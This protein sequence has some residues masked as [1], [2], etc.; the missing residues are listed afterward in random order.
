MAPYHTD[1]V[2]TFAN[3]S[4]LHGSQSGQLRV[5]HRLY[6]REASVL[7]TT[8]LGRLVRTAVRYLDHF[9]RPPDGMVRLSANLV[10]NERGAVLVAT[11]GLDVMPAERRLARL[12]WRRS[13]GVMPL[14]DSESLEVV[15]EPARFS[16]EDGV[17]KE[18]GTAWPPEPGESGVEPGRYPLQAVVLLGAHAD[19]LVA[20]ST[21]RRRAGYAALLDTAYE[22]ARVP[23]IEIVG[24]LD[25]QVPTV[26]VAGFESPEVLDVLR[27]LAN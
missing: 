1:V 6:R 8:S 27:R 16:I 26:R 23:D 9:V 13:D 22:S 7:R 10:V 5:L 24:R 14:L 21:A 4:L 19:H 20:E 25:G 15:V 2:T 17:A 11:G 18:L 12:G 3:L